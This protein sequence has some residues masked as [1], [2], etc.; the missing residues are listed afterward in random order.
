MT[1]ET[2]K[3]IFNQNRDL[4]VNHFLKKYMCDNENCVFTKNHQC[5]GVCLE[6]LQQKTYIE[7]LPPILGG[8]PP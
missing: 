8:D 7:C 1:Q 3:W 4:I 2:F 5:I 6:N